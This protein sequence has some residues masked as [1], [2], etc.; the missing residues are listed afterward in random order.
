LGSNPEMPVT[1]ILEDHARLWERADPLAI[2]LLSAVRPLF[3]GSLHRA[4]EPI[5]T[6]V[7]LRLGSA[8][9]LLTAAHVVD[10]FVDEDM[11]VPGNGRLEGVRARGVTMNPRP[12]KTRDDDLVDV[13]V[14]RVNPDHPLTVDEDFLTPAAIGIE[15]P[16]SQRSVYLSLGYPTKK[17]VV[18]PVARK[19]APWPVKYVGCPAT[20]ATHRKLGVHSSTHV[21]IEFDQR[22]TVTDEGVRAVMKPNGMSGGG[23]WW[24]RNARDAYGLPEARLTAILIEHR[25][26]QKVFVATRVRYHIAVIRRNWPDLISYLEGFPTP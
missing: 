16:W 10:N 11:F 26:Q 1:T 15:E 21:V 17:T 20:V 5:G 2:R 23:V 6:C 9:L 13:G 14:L 3:R 19:V 18:D 25:R 7:L 8:R 22:Q 24:W 4:P 12:G